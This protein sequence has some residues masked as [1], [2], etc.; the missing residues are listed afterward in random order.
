ML[1]QIILYAISVI[2][3]YLFSRKFLAKS[4]EELSEL[5]FLII[6]ILIP[7]LNI[8]I[9]TILIIYKCY[10][11]NNIIKIVNKFFIIKGGTNDDNVKGKKYR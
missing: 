8:L 7:F 1:I 2:L 11:K 4:I 3:C 6:F 9:I 5:I 10:D